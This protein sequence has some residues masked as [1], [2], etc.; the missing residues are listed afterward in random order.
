MFIDE[1]VRASV[2]A[3][4]CE[5]VIVCLALYSCLK[6][7][8]PSLSVKTIPALACAANHQVCVCVGVLMN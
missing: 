6:S 2:C 7:V 3:A 5:C 8:N 1:T 4:L